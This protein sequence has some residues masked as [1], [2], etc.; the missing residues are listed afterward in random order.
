MSWESIF[1]K[2]CA[3][4]HKR[5][6][7]GPQNGIHSLP[8]RVCAQ[9]QSAGHGAGRGKMDERTQQVLPVYSG[10]GCVSELW[11]QR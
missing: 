10:L 8:G 6:P 5:F 11:V 4:E 1:S 3:A 7:A 9:L 2:V